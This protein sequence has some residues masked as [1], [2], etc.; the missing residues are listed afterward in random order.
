ML[1]KWI[2]SWHFRDQ[3]IS[4]THKAVI[5][6]AGAGLTSMKLP[7]WRASYRELAALKE[8]LGDQLNPLKR[9]ETAPSGALWL[10]TGPL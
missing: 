7:L 6:V 5:H 9:P 2:A 8:S 4:Q 1:S 10:V 3:S